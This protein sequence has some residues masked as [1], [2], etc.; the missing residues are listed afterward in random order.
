MRFDD[1]RFASVG[2]QARWSDRQFDDDL[3]RFRLGSFAT[4]DALVSRPLGRGVSV[5]A[6]GENLLDERFDIGRTPVLTVGP[7]RTVRV[8]VR[9]EG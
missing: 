8:G 1:P 3:N 6:A 7:P 2:L 9:I 5:F 4:F